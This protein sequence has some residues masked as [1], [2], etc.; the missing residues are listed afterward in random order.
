MKNP[1]DHEQRAWLESL[2][3]DVRRLVEDE[4]ALYDDEDL[5][6]FE[7][8]EDDDWESSP[9]RTGARSEVVAAD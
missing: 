5:W 1:A 6:E 8:V 3:P 9:W 2:K 4:I 7:E